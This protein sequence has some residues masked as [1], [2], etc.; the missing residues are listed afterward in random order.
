[1]LAELDDSSV[2]DYVRS[3]TDAHRSHMFDIVMQFRAI[4]YDAE[5]DATDAAAAEEPAAAAAEPVLGSWAHHRAAL[6]V[7]RLDSLLP[8]CATAAHACRGS[9]I[10]PIPQP[11]R[12]GT[13]ERP[14]V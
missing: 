10:T 5:A 2:P 4:F 3:L 12:R 13:A 8:T 1:M 11:R 6:Y 9:C 7:E 14:R